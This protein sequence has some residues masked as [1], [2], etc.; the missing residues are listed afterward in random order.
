MA[1][2]QEI[3]VKWK[4]DLKFDALQNGRTIAIDGDARDSSTGVRPKALILTSLAGCTGIDVVD[5]LNKMRVGFTD[6]SMKVGGEMTE[7]H[8]RTYHTVRLIYSI[9][10]NNSDDQDKFRKAV[11]LSQDK[12]CGVSAMVRAFAKLEVEI[13]YL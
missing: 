11:N 7:Q 10:L 4:G 1:A 5:I 2:V 9:R 12:Y 8:P 6:F 13:V 3:E